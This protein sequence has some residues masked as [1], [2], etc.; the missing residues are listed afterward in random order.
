M[1]GY[2]KALSPEHLSTLDTINNLGSLY[3][4]QGKLE[5]AEDTY[6]RALKGYEAT[7]GPHH[8]RTNEVLT[9]FLDLEIA[10][11]RTLQTRFDLQ[12]FGIDPNEVENG[13]VSKD[14]VEAI[15]ENAQS[16][17]N[18]VSEVFRRD[19]TTA[20]DSVFL[21][22]DWDLP[23]F[24]QQECLGGQLLGLLVVLTTNGDHT[25]ATTCWEY[26]SWRW[27]HLSS[28]LLITLEKIARERDGATNGE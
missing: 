21:S 11:H 23:G 17:P 10:C 22:I 14:H 24:V 27:P 26:L 2:E 7:L 4:A 12:K 13:Y 3:G 19:S 20:K 18:T 8:E 28:R 6:K 25:Q 1:D 5:R 16:F 15:D 9:A